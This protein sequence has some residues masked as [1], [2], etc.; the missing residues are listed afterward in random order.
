VVPA[1]AT[2]DGSSSEP[3]TAR[4]EIMLDDEGPL[5]GEAHAEEE[6]ERAYEE[7]KLVG[8]AKLPRPAACSL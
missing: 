4:L 7:E 3:S 5:L 8:I 1:D 2:I 6:P